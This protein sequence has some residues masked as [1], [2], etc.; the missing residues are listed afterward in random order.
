MKAN[1]LA[2]ELGQK[3]SEKQRRGFK[4]GEQDHLASASSSDSPLTSS[5]RSICA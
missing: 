2:K 5:I 4:K 3:K 1:E